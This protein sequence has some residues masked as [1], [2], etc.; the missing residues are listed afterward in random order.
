MTDAKAMKIADLEE[1]IKT[2]QFQL[3]DAVWTISHI[4]SEIIALKA[5]IA[6][7]TEVDDDG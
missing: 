1:Q 5:R 3:R 6:E 7:L 2:K 4:P